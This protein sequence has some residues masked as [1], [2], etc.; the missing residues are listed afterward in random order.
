MSV[1]DVTHPDDL[2]TT[3]VGLDRVLGGGTLDY[4]R[5]KRYIRADGSI[6]W[7]DVRATLV[8]GP[9]GAPKYALAVVADITSRVEAKQE[10]AR[11][12]IM[13]NQSQKLEGIGRLAGG[14][15]HDFNNLLAVIL[16]YAELGVSRR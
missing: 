6:A 14:I 15:A 9:D 16:N 1:T 13:L 8:R 5:Q 12:E 10:Q 11:L 4:D 7:G 3:Q 2:A